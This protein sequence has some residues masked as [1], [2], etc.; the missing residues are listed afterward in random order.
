[1]GSTQATIAVI[2]GLLGVIATAVGI[3]TSWKSYQSRKRAEEA[4]KEAL[5]EAEQLKE[6]SATVTYLESTVKGQGE[7][8]EGL[9]SGLKRC[10]DRDNA[11]SEEV[12]RLQKELYTQ[13]LE[14][15]TMRQQLSSA[16]YRISVLEQKGT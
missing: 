11:K 14:L 16:Q 8:I 10:I 9:S 12:S 3:Y 4:A 15:N 6:K 5:K 13:A 7:V 1:M 2:G